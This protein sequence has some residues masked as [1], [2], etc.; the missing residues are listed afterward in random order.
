ME[1][2]NMVR[3]S[4]QLPNSPTAAMPH[5]MYNT[6]PIP[7]YHYPPYYY[8]NH[9]PPYIYPNPQNL[10][11]QQSP[12]YINHHYPSPNPNPNLNG[13]IQGTN[14]PNSLHSNS[15]YTFN[16]NYNPNPN[17]NTTNLNLPLTNSNQN[18]PIK[19]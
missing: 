8:P 7:M 6:I 4:E 10:I 1:Q 18:S 3:S 14:P 11:H 9:P 16:P 13:S 5:F 17:Q 2:Y 15:L 12:F 19:I